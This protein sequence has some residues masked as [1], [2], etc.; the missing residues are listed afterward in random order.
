[1]EKFEFFNKFNSP[2]LV[3]NNNVEVVYK[4]NVFNRC[5]PDFKTL[6]NFLHK[7]NYE[8]CPIDS[9]DSSTYKTYE[10]HSPIIQAVR[11]KE[12]FV[13]HISYQYKQTD[14]YYYDINEYFK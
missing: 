10:I 3:I 2:V 5:F 13:A 4:N 9:E 8:I 6:K 7:I 14:F 11:S 1:M 12:S